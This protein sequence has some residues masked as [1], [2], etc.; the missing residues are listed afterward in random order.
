MSE[1]TK[2][3]IKNEQFREVG[4]I[5]HKRHRKKTQQNTE[6]RWNNMDPTKKPKVNSGAAKNKQFLYLG[7]LQYIANIYPAS[8][9]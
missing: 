8:V 9:L 5:R 1:K 3:E 2:G 7:Q 6:K 4:N